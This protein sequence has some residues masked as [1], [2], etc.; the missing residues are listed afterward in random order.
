MKTTSRAALFALAMT[1]LAGDLRSQEP[2]SVAAPDTARWTVGAALVRVGSV[3]LGLNQLNASLAAN[4]RPT[5]VNAVPTLGISTYARRGRLIAGASIDGSL[6]HRAADASWTTKLLVNTATLDGGV[7]LLESSRATIT[8]VA[9]LGVRSTSLHFERRGDFTYSDGLVDPAR[10]VDLMS[11]SGMA[12]VGLNVE[13][14]F[15]SRWPGMF[16]LVAQTG[17]TRPFGAAVTFAGENHVRETPGE[18]A[19]LFARIGFAKPLGNR[20]RALDTASG[21]LLAMLFR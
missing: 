3:Q 2:F 4:G 5:F 7:V 8:G 18:G 10:G 14:R 1:A 17:V 6:P 21:A 9:S 13:R 20:G 11:K 12:E 15:V 16:S 19:G